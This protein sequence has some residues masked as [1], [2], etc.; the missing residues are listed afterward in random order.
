MIVVE[1]SKVF[2]GRPVS[3][4]YGQSRPGSS[5]AQLAIQR[6]ERER[7]RSQRN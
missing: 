3:V 2:G 1:Y 5:V 7:E 6:T 4:A